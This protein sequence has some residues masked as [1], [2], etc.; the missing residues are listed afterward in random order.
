MDISSALDAVAIIYTSTF[1][2]SSGTFYLGKKTLTFD[3][4]SGTIS[5]VTEAYKFDDSSGTV[6]SRIEAYTFG[7]SSVMT[8][9]FDVSSYT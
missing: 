5:S 1:D 9:M 7:Y 8:S 6:S 2:V 4:S 3:I